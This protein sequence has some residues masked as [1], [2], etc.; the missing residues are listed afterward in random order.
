MASTPPLPAF[1]AALPEYRSTQR[2]Q[3]LYSDLARQK[4]SNPT[5]YTANLEWW[6]NALQSVVERGLQPAGQPNPDHIVLHV[7]Q[8][9]SDAFMWDK[10][11]RPLGLSV[12]IVR[13]LSLSL[14]SQSPHGYLSKVVRTDSV[15]LFGPIAALFGLRQIYLRQGFSG[16]SSYFCPRC[17]TTF[18]G[19]QATQYNG[20]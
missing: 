17:S 10:V 15:S 6:R 11:G 14:L 20:V 19:F 1:L 5:G 7:D 13:S 9:L 8:S 2:I 12:V 18:M 4:L 3:S 16:W